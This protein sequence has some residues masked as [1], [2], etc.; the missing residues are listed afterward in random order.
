MPVIVPGMQ[1]HGMNQGAFGTELTCPSLVTGLSGTPEICGA[2]KWQFVEQVSRFRIRYRCKACHKTII[3]E[4]TA[5][6][7]HPYE[8]YGKNKWQRIVESWKGTHPLGKP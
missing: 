8:A 6:P 5:N 3:Y 1:R 4:F 7:G 2:N